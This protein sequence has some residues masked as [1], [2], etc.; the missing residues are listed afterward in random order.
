MVLL[1]IY[2]SKVSN[3]F[4]NFL[5]QIKLNIEAYKDARQKLKKQE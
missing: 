5:N 3:E 2:E 4:K 1:N